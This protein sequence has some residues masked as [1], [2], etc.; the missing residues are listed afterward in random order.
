MYARDTRP[1]DICVD[2][3]LTDPRVID[4]PREHLAGMHAHSP[5]ESVH[6]LDLD[7]LRRP[8]ITYLTAWRDDQLLACG[9]IK[10]LQASTPGQAGHGEIKSMRTTR[11][12]PAPRRCPRP[13]HRIAGACAPTRLCTGQ[14]GNRQRARLR[15]G[16][17]DVPP[18][19]FRRLR[20]L[21]RLPRRP[22][23]PVHDPGAR[24]RLSGPPSPPFI[25]AATSPGGIRPTGQP[26]A[27]R[28][29][30][31]TDWPQLL[32][33]PEGD[34]M[35]PATEAL[36]PA[37]S[38][39]AHHASISPGSSRAAARHLKKTAWRSRSFDASVDL[40]PHQIDAALFAQ[41][42]NQQRRGA[43]R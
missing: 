21:C 20:A 18:V 35:T 34:P 33:C 12:P 29:T 40:N 26:A 25:Q 42:P 5:A 28:S 3:E 6:A 16:A 36:E 38:T 4:L 22:V 7:G 39:T 8:E 32:E 2:R 13:A 11:A 30:A 23:Q 41:Q 43:G 24:W 17:G 9:A 14:P 1:I 27:G 15:A 37:A 31:A 10:E 19:R